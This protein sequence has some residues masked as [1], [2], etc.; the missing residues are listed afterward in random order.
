MAVI[1]KRFVIRLPAAAERHPHVLDDDLAIGRPELNAAAY[2]QGTVGHRYD[3]LLRVRRLRSAAIAPRIVERSG[4]AF[5]DYC[6]DRVRAGGGGQDPRPARGIEYHR[7]A[8]HTFRRVDTTPRVVTDID[9][10]IGIVTHCVVHSNLRTRT[11]ADPEPAPSCLPG[12]RHLS[13]RR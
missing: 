6:G 12:Y 4:R 10:V 7:Q 5:R 13:C 1:A 9:L 8:A 2:I 11:A 3:R